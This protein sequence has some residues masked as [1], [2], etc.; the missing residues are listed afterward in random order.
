MIAVPLRSVPKLP[1]SQSV[2]WAGPRLSWWRCPRGGGVPNELGHRAARVALRH[3]VRS[4][5][6][7]ACCPAHEP[8]TRIHDSAAWLAF[9]QA[10]QHFNAERELAEGPATIRIQPTLTEPSRLSGF[11]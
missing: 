3:G 11:P 5:D 4:P 10:I 9:D 8:Q 7:L 1:G 6:R 2:V